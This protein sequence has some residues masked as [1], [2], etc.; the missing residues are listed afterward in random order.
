[1]TEHAS[2]RWMPGTPSSGYLV[3]SNDKSSADSSSISGLIA[4]IIDK[5]FVPS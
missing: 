4:P 2:G 5:G 1:M 3:P